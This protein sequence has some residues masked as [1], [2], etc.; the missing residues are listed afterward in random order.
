MKPGN[1]GGHK[2]GS[3]SNAA[4]GF[5]R[6]AEQDGTAVSYGGRGGEGPATQ[7]AASAAADGELSYTVGA[8]SGAALRDAG[9]SGASEEIPLTEGERKARLSFIVRFMTKVAVRPDPDCWLWTA[10]LDDKGYG[11]IGLGGKHGRAMQA[12][13]ASWLVFLGEIPEGL[14]VC[15][16]C[17]VPKC[18][19]PAHLFLGTQTEN[20]A[21]MV[22]KGRNALGVRAA[23]KNP[24]HGEAIWCAVLTADAVRAV[25]QR[26]AGGLTQSAVAREFGVSRSTVQLIAAGKTWR[27]A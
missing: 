20:H 11:R 3:Q 17:D 13:R 21:D 19:N 4:G 15:H 6:A 10:C 18:V 8:V 5:V 23:P 7:A 9:R 25:R 16:R 24:V 27:R 22:R 2:N 1:H 26:I 14:C 12:H